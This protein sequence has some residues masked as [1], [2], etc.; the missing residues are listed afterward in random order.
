MSKKSKVIKAMLIAPLAGVALL[1]CAHMAMMKAQPAPPDS[2]FGFGPRVSANGSYRVTVEETQA[3]KTGKL[4]SSVVRVQSNDGQAID[5]AQIEIDGGMPQHGHGL[6]TRPRVSKALGDGR[7]EIA[8]L[9]F[10]MGGWW[11]LKFR[12]SNGAVA[13]SVTFNLAL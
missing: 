9:K 12:I 13:D 1:A 7:Y 3:Y 6:P 2:E 10:N 11:E 4:L 8:G 5:G